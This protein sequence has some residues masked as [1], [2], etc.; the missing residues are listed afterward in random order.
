MGKL[1]LTKITA[2]S[3]IITFFRL[4][5]GLAVSKIVAIHTGP[6][7][8]SLL[9]QLQSLVSLINGFVASQV[10]QGVSRYTAENGDNFEETKLFW[11]ASIKLS[12]LAVGFIVTI[13]IILSK[14]ISVWLFNNES[15]FFI[16]II[17]LAVV[18][19][20]VANSIFVGVINGLFD[21]NRF[22]LANILSIISGLLIICIFVYFWGLNGAL[23]A[24]AINNA[25]AGLLLVLIIRKQYW[26]RWDYWVGE[27]EKKHFREML[28]YFYMG[29]I[30]A[31]S[32]PVSLILVRIIITSH[33]SLA[34]SG[35]WQAV[36]RI[37]DAYLAILTTIVTVYYFPRTAA[38]KTRSEHLSVLYVGMKSFVP[39]AIMMAI[40][41]FVLKDLIVRVLFTQDFLIASPLFI[42]QNIGDV[43]RVISWLFATILLA[44]GYFRTSAVLE[45]IF[46]FMFPLLTYLLIDSLGFISSS[47]AYC[48]NY[49][50]YL[51]IV[52]FVYLK[53]LKGLQE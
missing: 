44:K 26:F 6:E 32:G 53:H 31:L 40:G 11:R 23:V 30:G 42:Y 13:G 9:G 52:F 4:I 50:M 12:A 17:A 38:A 47:V 14:D 18:P 7:G 16:V 24:V 21:Y 34:E 10:S 48:I 28:N 2:F 5:S 29:I 41:V 49:L 46:S 36:A 1:N 20:N 3:G 39:L 25:V 37:S 43:L 35:Y 8:I 19:L 33:L 27:T 15:Y 51:I 45:I 22:F